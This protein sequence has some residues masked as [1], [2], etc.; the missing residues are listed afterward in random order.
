[1]SLED[2][3]HKGH[4]VTVLT[5]EREEHACSMEGSVSHIGTKEQVHNKGHVLRYILEQFLRQKQP[6]N[7]ESRRTKNFM[8]Y[9]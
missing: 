9:I 8:T 2:S 3:H 5:R 4:A 7:P 6:S 1:M